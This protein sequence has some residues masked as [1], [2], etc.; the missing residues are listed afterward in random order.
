MTVKIQN[1]QEALI[2]AYLLNPGL[3]GYKIGKPSAWPKFAKALQQKKL[4]RVFTEIEL[5]LLPVL[6]SMEQLG[7][8]LDLKELQSLKVKLAARIKF[9]TQ[10]I[11]K[12]AGQ[13][14]NIA[15]PIQLRE[16]LFEKLQIPTEELRKTGKTKAFSTAATELDKLRG[17]HPIIELISEYRELTKLQSTYVEALPKLVGPDGRLHTSYSQTT[18]ATGRLSS[19]EPNLQNIPIRT[20][21]GNRVRKAFVAEQGFVLASLDYSQIEL[22]IAATLSEDEEMIKIFSAGGGSAFGGKDGDFHA[23]TA[24][25][26]FNV[27]EAA[28]TKAQRR[29]AKTINFSVLYGVSAFG[30]S[31]RSEMTQTEA[32]DYIKKYYEIFKDLKKY[33]DQTVKQVH[34]TGYAINPLSRLRYFPEIH[35]PIYAVR[36]A[37]ER[38]A[39]N[40]PLQSLAADIMKLAMLKIYELIK[41]DAN[42]RLLLSVH[43]ELVFEIKQG[44]EKKYIPKLREIM[45]T[46]YKLKVPIVVE[47]KVGKNWMEMEPY[48]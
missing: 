29:V 41:E 44:S 30:L 32:R 16:I 38:A 18:A 47:A 37:A 12:Q 35:S 28:V 31:S 9:L 43:D 1:E 24:A 48:E 11:H 6:K 20:E 26:I 21:L 22:R 40:M 2:A 36:A 10:Q 45:E 25:R 33:I 19:S 7:V 15:S 17:L 23:A 34:K 5:P 4:I 3:R 13:E 46:V 39:F 42:C 8:K 14:F 27:A